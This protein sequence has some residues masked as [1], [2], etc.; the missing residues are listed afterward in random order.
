M[1]D[2]EIAKWQREHYGIGV[3]KAEL[4]ILVGKAWNNI[5]ASALKKSFAKTGLYDDLAMNQNRI[6][7]KAIKISNFKQPDIDAYESIKQNDIHPPLEPNLDHANTSNTVPP[8]SSITKRD[9]VQPESSLN[10]STPTQ[11]VKRISLKELLLQKIARPANI[12]MKK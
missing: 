3:S 7:R 11:I 12:K 10:D 4:S 2:E 6:N 9:Q 8:S 1:W 5:S